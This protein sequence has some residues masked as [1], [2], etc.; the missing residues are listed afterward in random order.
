[1]GIRKFG[2][3]IHLW[4]FD[5]P[6]YAEPNE[7]LR[8][9]VTGLLTCWQNS[10]VQF[11]GHE[12]PAN[13]LIS[14]NTIPWQGYRCASFTK[15]TYLT[16]VVDLAST[17]KSKNCEI[18]FMLRVLGDQ[19]ASIINFD[20][21]IIL[22]Q[23][24]N[25]LSLG[26]DQISG[27]IAYN[28]WHHVLLRFT[29]AGIQPYINGVNIKTV[30]YPEGYN[31]MS[32]V[33]LGRF[34][35]YIDE[36]VIRKA[37]SNNPVVIPTEPYQGTVNVN[38]LGG[39]G[40]GGLGNV[41]ISKLTQINSYGGISAVSGARL[42]IS[43]WNTGTYGS[44]K[45]GDEVMIHVTLPKG[46]GDSQVGD[47]AFRRVINVSGSIIELNSAI[48]EF[49]LSQQTLQNYYVQVITI[50]NYEKLTLTNEIRP[51]K[52]VDGIG[53]IIGL[54]VKGDCT[55]SGKIITS[56]YGPKRR[57]KQQMTHS[58]L[59]ENFIVNRGGGIFITCGGKLTTGAVARLGASFDGSL[60]AGTGGK[61]SSGSDGG[62]GYGGGG[63]GDLHEESRGGSGG[64]GGG[65]G[66]A[67]FS[68][69]TSGSAGALDTGGWG[70]RIDRGITRGGTQGVT[71]G[72]NSPDDDNATGGGGALGN[73]GDLVLEQRF[74]SSGSCIIIL[75]KQ[76]SISA[77]SIS[78]GGEGGKLLSSND[79]G[80]GGGGTGLCYI[81]L[82]GGK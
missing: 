65:G 23:Q 9:E 78:T 71:A 42:T 14:D 8:D 31:Q 5:Y 41:T 52:Y 26:S 44:V 19:I 33:I 73:A 60:G 24:Q 48:T 20:N 77:S 70:V 30:G 63:A 3:I 6:Y 55:I 32:R 54:R 13:P 67:N 7:G 38:E 66:G 76:A 37:S 21:A 46:T 15:D 27:G 68:W 82:T 40:D 81:A 47:Y 10:G 43:K 56:S 53:G 1:M 17:L 57:D 75:A 4:H 29:S 39:Y 12:A 11:A 64:V 35:G 61:E 59:I 69:A 34:Q 16:S 80:Q 36:L 2:D 25:S 51:M 62:A 79:V 58:K 74:T 49:N 50:P 72:G 22:T 45:V 28:K 18:E